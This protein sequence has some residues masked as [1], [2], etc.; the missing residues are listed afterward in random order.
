MLRVR[1]PWHGIRFT[2]TLAF[3]DSVHFDVLR[4]TRLVGQLGVVGWR[5]RNSE[6]RRMRR[7]GTHATLTCYVYRAAITFMSA[8]TCPFT[9]YDIL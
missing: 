5:L 9:C 8:F 4:V 7:R 1:G 2:F 3:Y 6:L